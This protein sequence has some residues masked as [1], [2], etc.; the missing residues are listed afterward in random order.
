MEKKEEE[1]EKTAL[2]ISEAHPACNYSPAPGGM[3]WSEVLKLVKRLNK[4]EEILI[5]YLS[6]GSYTF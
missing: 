4:Q 5:T 3:I 6:Q 1:E 2:G